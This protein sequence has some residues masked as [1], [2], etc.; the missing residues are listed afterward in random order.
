MS[1]AV[2]NQQ[3]TIEILR[4]T[5][6]VADQ[7][8]MRK[9][10]LIALDKRR[11]ET[12]EATRTLKNSFPSGSAKVWITVG[13]MLMKM[14]RDKALEL[15]EKDAAQIEQEINR[16][17]AEQKVLVSKQRDLEHEKPLR[18]FDLKPLTAAEISAIKANAPAF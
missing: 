11:Q 4:E 9:Q 12:R 18:G 2:S 5:E 1:A 8:L 13:S 7:V 3:K 15:L 10:E 17:R 6:R 14:P 16:L